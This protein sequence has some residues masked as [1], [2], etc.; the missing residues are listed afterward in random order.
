M[1]YGV[2]YHASEGDDA[3]MKK[4]T[5]Y[6][7]EDL[8][9]SLKHAAKRLKKSESVI[10]RE[11]LTDYLVKHRPPFPTSIGMVEGDGTFDARNTKAFLRDA[12]RRE[13]EAMQRRIEEDR[14]QRESQ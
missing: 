3:G 9:L 8:Q 7:P 6:L 5:L 1:A 11:A 10:I 4:T 14:A 13:L 2:W 12:Y